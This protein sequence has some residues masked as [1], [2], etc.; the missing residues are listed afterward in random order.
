MLNHNYF[1]QG[2]K[3]SELEKEQPDKVAKNGELF[4][5]ARQNKAVPKKISIASEDKS[6]KFV[7]RQLVS[8]TSAPDDFNHNSSAQRLRNYDK[9]RLMLLQDSGTNAVISS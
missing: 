5:P 1:S 2:Q 3:I 8:F 7:D 6:K 4:S 9:E